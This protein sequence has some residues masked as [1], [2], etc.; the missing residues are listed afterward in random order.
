MNLLIVGGGEIGAQIADALHRSHNVTVLDVDA[1]REEAF[2]AM[3]V[4]FVRGNG[5]DPDDL[6]AAGADK[7]QSFIACTLNDD[8]NVLSCLA[9]KGLGAKETMAF[10]TRQRYVDAFRPRG[11]MQSIGLSVDRVLWPQR[12]LAKQIVDIVR[13][14]RALDSGHFA[15]GRITMVEYRLEPGDPFIDQSLN[16]A[17]LPDDVLVVGSIRDDVFSVPSGTTRLHEGDKVVFMGTSE[18]MR[19]L[20]VRF[21]PSR[22]RLRVALVGGGNVGFMVAER[23]QD[24][25]ADITIVE[26]D[27]ARADKLAALLPKALVLRG[28]G[29][30]LELLEQERLEDADVMIAVTSD[31]ATNLLVSLLAKQLG[32]PKVITRVGRAHNRRLFE[33]V[34]I[35]APLT[36]RTAAV[37]EVLNWLKIDEVDHLA[38]IEDRAEVMEVTFP[39]DA[40]PGAVHALGSPPHSL[41]GAILRKQKVLIPRGDTVIQPG[42]HLFLITTPDNVDTVARWLERQ[43]RDQES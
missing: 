7:A 2:R 25:G 31:D 19:R 5:A 40:A 35:D 10:V 16:E 17:R 4:R 43:E 30:D 8:I 33:R 1:D 20:E 36:P 39:Y 29:T 24:L 22:R 21:T 13:V 26:N 6:R 27:D 38:T 32:I 15:G 11:A 3:D 42:D 34:G 37:Q 14:P 28:D 12:T 18:A 23:L 9:A 41:I